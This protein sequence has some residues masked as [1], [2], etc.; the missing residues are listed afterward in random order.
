MG[1]VSDG[2]DERRERARW[3]TREEKDGGGIGVG[4]SHRVASR[5]AERT[6]ALLSFP[7]SVHKPM[8]RQAGRNEG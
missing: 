6:D 5:A 3:R 7:L 4:S 8:L 1:A 2:R